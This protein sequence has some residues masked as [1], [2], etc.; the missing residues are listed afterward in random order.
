MK[1]IIN[2]FIWLSIVTCVIFLIVGLML[3]FYPTVS[4]SVI[5]YLIA[6]LL[7]IV[8]FIF[9]YNYKS[10][11]LLTNFLTTGT[12][13]IL[14][15]TILI[16]YPNAL[17]LMIPVIVGIWMIIN[18]LIDIQVSLT[19]RKIRYE[20]WLIS[21]LLSVMSIVCGILIIINPQAGAE[22]LTTFFGIMVV[23]YAVTNIANVLVFKT[24]IVK[25]EKLLD[26]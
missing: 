5:S 19:L 8:G 10:S 26:K 14:L 25:I 11:I 18:G 21:T 3:M 22:A 23:I 15:G 24:N 17:A 2:K 7:I 12:L 13:A 1:K 20:G 9:V 16:L 4:I 6:G